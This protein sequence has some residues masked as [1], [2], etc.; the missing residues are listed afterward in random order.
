[1]LEIPFEILEELAEFPRHVA[2]GDDE[3]IFLMIALVLAAAG[4]AFGIGLHT[5]LTA[6]GRRFSL[7]GSL[8]SMLQFLW[9]VPVVA[10][11]LVLVGR[12][13]DRVDRARPP[14]RQPMVHNT[15][16]RA[17]ASA[18]SADE[19][20]VALVDESERLEWVETRREDDPEQGR[21]LV[22]VSSRQFAT[23]EQAERDAITQAMDVL[24]EDLQ[25]TDPR[26]DRL[27]VVPT[28]VVEHLAVRRRYVE[29]IVRSTGNQEFVVHRVHLQVELSDRVRSELRP[30]WR[31]Q[32]VDRRL[33]SL[34]AVVGFLTV[35]LGSLSAYLR[36]NDLSEGRFQNRLRFAAASLVTAAGLVAA[37]FI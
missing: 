18:A 30:Y 4:L 9:L 5:F 21:A 2:Q 15:A 32:V 34:G 28:G 35:L 29:P 14:V 1:M 10:V 13:H 16:T 37:V 23:V 20:P 6:T 36:L 25:R 22:T 3:S 7:R 19:S 26:I 27:N 8:G 17:L 12:Y 24:V 31:S 11:V 33:W